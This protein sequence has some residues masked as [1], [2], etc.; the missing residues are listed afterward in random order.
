MSEAQF[1][2]QVLAFNQWKK[3][4]IREA[5]RF[6][7]WL[8]E[9][10]LMTDDLKSQI[11]DALHQLVSD[12]ITVAFAG[13]FSRGK[14]E[15]INAL[16]FSHYGRRLLP[17][18]IGRTTM[19]P[20][21]LF[22]DRRLDKSY[23]RLLPVETRASNVSIDSFKRLPDKWKHIELDPNDPESARILA[24]NPAATPDDLPF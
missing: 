7:N 6:R 24:G 13:E 17:S 12:Q 4:I 3:D 2:R 9:H 19:C 22:Y 20:T 11:E 18:T 14:T 8:N 23:I 5:V 1:T 21:E 10:H 15:L 16:F